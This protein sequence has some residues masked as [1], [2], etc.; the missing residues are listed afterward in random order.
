MESSLFS[1]SAGPWTRLSFPGAHSNLISWFLILHK[2]HNSLQTVKIFETYIS[3]A[4]RILGDT[5]AS[6]WLLALLI[7][8]PL[9][10][11][12]GMRPLFSKHIIL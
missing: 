4:L 8:V 5:M 7:T 6:L 2:L 12:I 3:V 1:A 9:V 11:F 10:L